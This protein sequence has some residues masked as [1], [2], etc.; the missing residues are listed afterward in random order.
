MYAVGEPPLVWNE[1]MPA[2][3]L[4]NSDDDAPVGLDAT[5]TSSYA[6]ALYKYPIAAYPYADLVRE[7]PSAL[8]DINVSGGGKGQSA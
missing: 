3:A 2:W 5:P 8:H 6:K 1:M 4:P 7:N